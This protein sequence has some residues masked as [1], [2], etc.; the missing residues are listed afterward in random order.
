MLQ[1][2]QARDID[3]IQ[4]KLKGRTSENRPEEQKAV[5]EIIR[6]IRQRGDEALFEYTRR[7]DGFEANEDNLVVGREE[8]DA[9]LSQVDPALIDVMKEAALNIERFHNQQKRQG[10][11]ME[12]GGKILGQLYLPVEHAGVYVPGG[13]SPYPSS[14]LMNIIPAKCAGVE[15]IYVATPATG[16]QVSPVILAAA[17]IAGAHKI[18]RMGGAQAIAAFAYGTKSVPAVDKVTGPGNIYVALAKRSVYGQVGIDMIAGPSEVLVIADADANPA[19]VAADLLSQ[20]EHDEMAACMLVSSSGELVQ[21]V[22][23]ELALQ[24][25]KLE[26]KEIAKKSLAAYGMAV[27]TDS[28][29]QAVDVANRIAPEHLEICTAEPRDLLPGIKNAGAI[30]LGDYAPEPLGDYFAGTNHVIPTNGT[31]RFSSPLNVDDFQKKS[32][33][34]YYSKEEFEKV[35]RKVEAFAQSEGFGAHARSATIRFE[36]QGE[37]S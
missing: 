27:V 32:S 12:E 23:D 22:Q 30:F 15:N 16:G 14:V 21:K 36:E 7:F 11:F 2:M 25:E 28:L 10:W 8:I 35:Y 26:K 34:L 5:D 33:V 3:A 31:A 4:E 9:A 18:F 1:V 29:E 17:S 13:K 37:K 19:F 20:A 24:V 6:N